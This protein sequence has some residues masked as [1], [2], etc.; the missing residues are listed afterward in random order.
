[1][2]TKPASLVL[3]ENMSK[4]KRWLLAVLV[5]GLGG[6]CTLDNPNAPQLAG[7]SEQGRSIELRA[8]PDHLV[9]DGW[10]SSVIEG[11]LRGP[12]SERL[13]GVSISFDIQGFVDQGNLAPLNGP[14]PTYGGVESGPVAAMT[15]SDGVARARY[16]APFR[17]DQPSDTTVTLL[18]RED[19]TN[20]RGALAAAG[21]ADIFLRAADRPF[22]SPFPTPQP[23]CPDATAAIELSNTCSGGELKVG[24]PVLALGAGSEAGTGEVI[25]N[26]IWN[27]G[28]GVTDSTSGSSNSHTYGSASAGFHVTIQLTVI[29]SCG[30]SATEQVDADVV[31][32][33]P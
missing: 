26:Y 24:T 6:S 30:S 22:P 4:T 20:F 17:T 8:V 27:W 15:D 10:S 19:G 14:R 21:R 13:S 1:M 33:C 29:N 31:N 25:T 16:W 28:D 18:A 9:A 23:G 3:E 11:V 32:I 12:N 5:A 2:G 7:P